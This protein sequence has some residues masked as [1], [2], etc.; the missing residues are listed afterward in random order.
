LA[1]SSFLMIL[2][3]NI[4]VGFK[5]VYKA[6]SSCWWLSYPLFNFISFLR[7]NYSLSLES[8]YLYFQIISFLALFS[9]LAY[10]LTKTSLYLKNIKDLVNFLFLRTAINSSSY[11]SFIYLRRSCFIVKKSL[12][13]KFCSSIYFI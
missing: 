1:L 11:Y 9:S 3:K 7:F 6:F 5:N 2:L 13:L 12:Y 8:Y 4:I 10:F